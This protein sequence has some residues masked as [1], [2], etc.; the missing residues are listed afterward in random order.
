M[1]ILAT[2]RSK[3]FDG[4]N[5]K[6]DEIARD[7]QEVL[8]RAEIIK[9]D[10]QMTSKEEQLARLAYP[11]LNALLLTEQRAVAPFPRGERLALGTRRLS[12]AR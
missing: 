4:F 1:Q 3:E 5:E 11:D 6:D 12:E 8:K 2:M 7:A 9:L 10:E